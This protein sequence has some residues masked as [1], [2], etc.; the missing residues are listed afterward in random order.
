MSNYYGLNFNNPEAYYGQPVT[1][2]QAKELKDS[3]SGLSPRQARNLERRVNEVEGSIAGQ[4][5]DRVKGAEAQR[6]RVFEEVEDGL[7][8]A[9]EAARKVQRRMEL[10]KLSAT[11]ARQ[12]L[13]KIG[14]QRRVLQERLDQLAKDDAALSDLAETPL[15]DFEDGYLATYPALRRGL[16]VITADDL[17][18][19]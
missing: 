4:L 16:P 5:A 15:E 6:N 2:R 10:G 19:A 1:L 9:T 13:S 8:E 3:A 18:Q 7:T 11:E 14:A 12:A 17:N